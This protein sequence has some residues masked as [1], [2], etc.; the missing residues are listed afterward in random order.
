MLGVNT[1]ASLEMVQKRCAA[2]GITWANIHD[3]KE[4]KIARGWGVSGYPSAW[5]IDRDGVI[6]KCFLG[7]DEKE[8]DAAVE[9]LMKGTAVPAPKEP[10]KDAP[11]PQAA[12]AVKH[13][14]VSFAAPV[15]LKAG[16][17]LLGENRYFPSPTFRDMNGDG[18]KDIVVGDLLGRLT[19]AL[20]EAGSG[21]I[22][23]GAE[24]KLQAS[25][26]KDITFHNW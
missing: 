3:G 11:A 16:E 18:L 14:P 24:T 8:L 6:R 25:D 15:Q 2:E 21:P 19:V 5:L 17:K 4:K 7:I 23:F 22:S 1:D 9:Q 20:R 12:A 10:V 13:A 26:G